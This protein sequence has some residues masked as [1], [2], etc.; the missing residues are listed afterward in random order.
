MAILSL[1]WI[2]PGS[3]SFST[4]SLSFREV[5]STSR[6]KRFTIFIY[7]EKNRGGRRSRPGEEQ[8]ARTRAAGACHANRHLPEPM[9]GAETLGGPSMFCRTIISCLL[10]GWFVVSGN[11]SGQ[12][13]PD[14]RQ[15]G[16]ASN[17]APTPDANKTL[18]LIC[19]GAND[20]SSFS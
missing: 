11:A 9:D 7:F 17:T 19:V 2:L 12:I 14:A 1:L 4:S 18:A 20:F 10:A 15:A 8:A 3:G 13:E 5:T 6:Q 16:T